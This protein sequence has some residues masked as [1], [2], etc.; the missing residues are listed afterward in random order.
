MSE[1]KALIPLHNS[2]RAPVPRRVEWRHDPRLSR[3][4]ILHELLVAPRDGLVP[5]ADTHIIVRFPE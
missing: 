5:L 3:E 4:E 1:V 2:R